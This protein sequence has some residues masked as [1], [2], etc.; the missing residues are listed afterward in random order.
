MKR[1]RLRESIYRIRGRIPL[2]P[3]IQRR[4]Y[5]VPGPNA[6]WHLDGNHKINRWRLVV[7]GGIDGFSRMVTFL[8]CSPNNRSQTVLDEFLKGVSEFGLPSRVR[9]DH[10]GENVKVWNYMENARGENRSSFIAG[11]SVHNTRI[12]RL[13]RDVFTSVSSSFCTLFYELEEMGVLDHDNEAD[14]FCLHFVFIPR[15]N[16]ALLSFQKAWN[17]HPLS[18]ENN[19]CPLQ[20]YTAYSL[21]SSLF[22]DPRPP[23]YTT[24]SDNEVEESCERVMIPEVNIPLSDNSL[25]QLYG[26]IN[27]LQDCDDFGKQFY[28]DTVP[29]L[30]DLMRADNLL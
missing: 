1:S 6:V 24:E 21:G 14:L 29:L 13:W 22:E 20:L 27:P 17:Y 4:G 3:A 16:Q 23:E 15:I 8:K 9:T 2:Q 25:Q 18:T 5:F 10:G 19:L 28:L 30:F 11:C 12:E 7:H 26:S